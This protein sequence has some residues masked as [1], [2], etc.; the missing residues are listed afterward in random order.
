[1]RSEKIFVFKK[2]RKGRDPWGGRVSVVCFLRRGPAVLLDRAKE[3]G[4]GLE[5]K[6]NT[7]R[8]AKKTKKHPRLQGGENRVRGGG[9][10]NRDKE[11][12]RKDDS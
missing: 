10:Y 9:G 3:G 5:E 11:K 1:M 6:R 2:E 7:E 12:R 4:E 8:R